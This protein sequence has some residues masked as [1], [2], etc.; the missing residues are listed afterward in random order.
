M[1]I[2]PRPEPDRPQVEPDRTQPEPDWTD[3]C[4]FIMTCLEYDPTR[5]ESVKKVYDAYKNFRTSSSE[6]KLSRYWFFRT[7]KEYFRT[8]GKNIEYKA[9]QTP[10][11]ADM[12]FFNL[13]LRADPDKTETALNAINANKAPDDPPAVPDPCAAC[14]DMNCDCCPLKDGTPIKLYDPKEAA[15]AMLAGR[16]L[17][18]DK[19]WLFFWEDSSSDDKAGFFF[20]DEKGDID[21]VRDFSGL[22]EEARYV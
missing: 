10:D 13:G 12:Y 11:G 9:V 14:A 6:K 2:R 3:V 8:E 17:K 16:V 5:R 22:Y 1:T 21:R 19:G 7:I 18:N 20:Q 4:A 15:A